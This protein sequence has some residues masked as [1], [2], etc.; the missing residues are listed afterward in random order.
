MI[1]E[2]TFGNL[3]VTEAT[4]A[5]LN[6]IKSS[7]AEAARVPV[8][9]VDVMSVTAGSTVVGFRVFFDP[10]DVEDKNNFEALVGADAPAIFEDDPTL[11]G[12]GVEKQVGSPALPPLAPLLLQ[13]FA[14]SRKAIHTSS[15]ISACGGR[16]RKVSC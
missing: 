13:P 15:A 5:L 7:V 16:R 2:L 1:I 9:W 12:L 11:A 4:D 8:G 10:E 3:D 6:G 14:A